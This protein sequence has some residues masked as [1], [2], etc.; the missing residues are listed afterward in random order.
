MSKKG[1]RHICWECLHEPVDTWAKV[2]NGFIAILIVV[3]VGTI[4]F[5]LIPQLEWTLPYVKAFEWFTVAVFSIEYFLRTWSAEKPL[6]YVFSWIGLIDFVAIFPFYLGLFGIY[7]VPHALLSL[8]LLRI[9][10]LGRLYYTERV[11]LSKLAHK[12]H[13]HFNALSDEH[14]ERI[15]YKHPVIFVFTLIPPIVMTSIGLLVIAAFEFN[16]AAIAIA[17]ISFAFALLYFLKAWLDFH[18][19]VIYVTNQRI[20]MQNRQLFGYRL[21]DISYPSI[22]NIRPDN[23]GVMRYVFGYGDVQIET[24]SIGGNRE[25]SN[26]SDPMGV[27]HKISTN[28]IKAIEQGDYV[29]RKQQGQV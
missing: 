26:I 12:A 6:R 22:T 8:R 11:S 25:F 17:A 4:P 14:I 19:D 13:G 23:T 2:V 10:K 7:D 28:R 5:Y 16:P 9:L 29:L 15:V 1:F 20:I 3:S 24:A 27:V 18:Y 21:N